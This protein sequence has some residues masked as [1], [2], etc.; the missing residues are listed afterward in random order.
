[1]GAKAVIL[2]EKTAGG[3][4]FVNFELK[5]KVFK[6]FCENPRFSRFLIYNFRFSRFAGRPALQPSMPVNRKVCQ[7]YDQLMPFIMGIKVYCPIFY[8][9][10]I[11]K[12]TKNP[13]KN[14]IW[15]ISSKM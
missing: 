14:K 10:I 3:E 15:E 7:L 11:L 8:H 4:I 13:Q 1:M 12:K 5:L 6:R 9:K 2:S